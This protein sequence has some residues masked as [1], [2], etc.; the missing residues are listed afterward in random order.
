MLTLPTQT[1]EPGNFPVACW[2]PGCVRQVQGDIQ[3]GARY[4]A[5]RYLHWLA[6]VANGI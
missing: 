4:E 6:K 1:A 2:C 3:N 5:I